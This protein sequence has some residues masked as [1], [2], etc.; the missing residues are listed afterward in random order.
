MMTPSITFPDEFPVLKTERLT[1]SEFT[2]NDVSRFFNLRSDEEFMKYLGLFPMKRTSEARDRVHSIIQ[3]FKTG[4]AISWKISLQ[5]STE[6]IGYIGFWEIDFRHFRGEIGFGIDQQFQ[7]K[8]YMSEAM[9]KI[10]E[11]GFH[12][13][14]LHSIKADVDPRN[15]ASIQLLENNNFIKE[16]HFRENYFFNGNFLDS[17]F[18]GLLINDFKV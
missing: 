17:D 16:A 8:G 6:L 15:K 11:Y 14:G 13:L 3:A 2:A 9:P 18:Y 4:E 1:L 12:Q 5:N 7:Q 10:L